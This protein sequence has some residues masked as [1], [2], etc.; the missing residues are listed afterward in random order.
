MKYFI[1]LP[2][3][4][5]FFPPFLCEFSL[6]PIQSIRGHSFRS[7]F[8]KVK[9]LIH[10]TTFARCHEIFCLASFEIE[11]FR[12]LLSAA[13]YWS[14]VQIRSDSY[15]ANKTDC[16]F[17]DLLLSRYYWAKR[18]IKDGWFRVTTD[19]DSIDDSLKTHR[20]RTSAGFD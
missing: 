6:H 2:L 14:S 7:A 12:L 18:T 20:R 13:F 1:S 9:I 8:L 10:Q 4:V 3:L 11:S 15:C 5:S 17:R 19:G 16:D